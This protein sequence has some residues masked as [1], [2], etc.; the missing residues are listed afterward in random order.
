MQKSTKMHTKYLKMMQNILNMHLKCLQNMPKN[1]ILEQRKFTKKQC[2]LLHVN[3]SKCTQNKNTSK[4][5]IRTEMTVRHTSYGVVRRCT[6]YGVRPNPLYPLK[7][8]AAMV[9]SQ[10]TF[11]WPLMNKA[12]SVQKREKLPFAR[13]LFI[14]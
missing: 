6:S 7:T 1:F 13:F 8:H 9:T 2:N 12:K 11:C 4:Y 14:F 5:V 10:S 3:N